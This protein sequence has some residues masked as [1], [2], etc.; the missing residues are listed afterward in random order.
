MDRAPLQ[1]QIPWDG[2]DFREPYVFCLDYNYNI[3]LL[4]RA[5][6]AIFSGLQ[7]LPLQQSPQLEDELSSRGGVVLWQVE[8]A[9]G[10]RGTVRVNS[11]GPD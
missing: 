1:K 9:R 8:P 11:T 5:A 10:P 2:V 7:G 3:G 6:M 4:E